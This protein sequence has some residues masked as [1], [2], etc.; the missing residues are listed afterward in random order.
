MDT[1]FLFRNGSIDL[2]PV[3]C[4]GLVI[5]VD[6]EFLYKLQGFSLY[7]HRGSK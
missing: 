3:T 1:V 2:Y 4:L 6:S 7:M 5:E